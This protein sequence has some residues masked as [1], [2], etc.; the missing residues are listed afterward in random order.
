MEKIFNI[1]PIRLLR[2]SLPGMKAI[3]APPVSREDLGKVAVAA[4][5]GEIPSS[6]REA[7]NGILTIEDIQRES[8]R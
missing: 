8:Q 6:N 2:H 5:L 7:S 1:A 3:L 4:A